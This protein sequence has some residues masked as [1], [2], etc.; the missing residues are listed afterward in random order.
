MQNRF[1]VNHVIFDISGTKTF[2]IQLLR[3]RIWHRR[4]S[5]ALPEME[6]WTNIYHEGKG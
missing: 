1:I 6:F 2:V 3:V 5:S 4:S